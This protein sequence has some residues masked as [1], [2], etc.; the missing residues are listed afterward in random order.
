VVC[1][2]FFQ[3]FSSARSNST[4]LSVSN[5]RKSPSEEALASH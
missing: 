4:H 1:N 2:I 3:F 5:L